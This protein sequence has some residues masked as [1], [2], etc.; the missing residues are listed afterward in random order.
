[1]MRWD[2][3]CGRMRESGFLRKE[4]SYNNSMSN[5][6]DWKTA[7]KRHVSTAQLFVEFLELQMPVIP[8]KLTSDV[9]VKIIRDLFHKEAIRNKLDKLANKPQDTEFSFDNFIIDEYKYDL[10]EGEEVVLRLWRESGFAEAKRTAI[11]LTKVERLR[12]KVASKKVQREITVE[13]LTGLLRFW[14]LI[15]V[16]SVLYIITCLLCSRNIRFEPMTW[17]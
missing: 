1:M 10:Q 3:V 13:R 6:S 9:E 7:Y 17:S 12:L 8:D 5:N 16:I 4:L 15:I 14:W 2:A 11:D